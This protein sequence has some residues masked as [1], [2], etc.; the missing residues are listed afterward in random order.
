ME[1]KKY[2]EL[3]K[4]I[5]RRSNSLKNPPKHNQTNR[6]QTERE[7]EGMRKDRKKLMK[8]QVI[9]YLVTKGFADT[10]TEAEKIANVMSENWKLSIQTLK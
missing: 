1:D 2:Q 8:E 9:D 5:A 10:I 4:A 6:S 7:V 3:K